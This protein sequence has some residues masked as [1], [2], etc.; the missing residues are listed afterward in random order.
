MVEYDI[1]FPNLDI[2]IKDAQEVELEILLEFDRICKKHNINYFLYSGTLLGAIRH[3]GFIPWDD[4][5][6]VCMLREEYDKFM[7]IAMNELD[8]KYFLQNYDTDRNYPLQ[9]SK[10]RKNNT[11]YMEVNLSNLKMHQGIF[12][13]IFPYDN[14]EPNTFLGK[15]QRIIVEKMILIN[16]CRNKERNKQSQNK[17]IILF[18]MFCYYILKIIP[19]TLIDK[20]ITKI[21][22]LFNN[23]NTEYISD[24]S[25]S[26]RKSTYDRFT[27]KRNVFKSKI[28]CEFE[29][30][31]F[32]VPKD[33]DYVLTKNYGDY[34]KLPAE[35]EQKPHHGINK[36]SFNE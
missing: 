10:L 6:D 32:P 13:D 9:F 11:T 1:K 4:D 2:K 18:R 36:I 25:S 29:G 23:K 24:L 3:K 7:K 34:M 8:N 22:T 26:K 21:S 35:K 20:F 31:K 30:Y 14:S 27:I 28:F 15:L 16:L 33:Y 19:K 17:L 12:I 5:I